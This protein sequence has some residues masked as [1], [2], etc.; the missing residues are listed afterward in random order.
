[1]RAEKV[2]VK[3]NVVVEPLFNQWYAWSYLISPVTSAL[4]VANQ[5][6]KIM[7]SFLAAPQVHVKALENPAMRGGP[8]INHPPSGAGEIRALLEQTTKGQAQVINFAASV[9]TLHEVLSQQ[10]DGHSLEPL[11]R[12]VPDQLRGYVE[13]VY[14]LNQSPSARFIE[15]LLYHSPLHDDSSQSLSLFLTERDG[16]PF[17]F[18]TPRLDSPGSLNLPL[19]FKD[20]RV[21]EFSRMKYEPGR[22]EYM[23]DLLGV[24]GDKEE[25]LATFFTDEPPQT[26]RFEGEGVR[27]RYFGHACVLVETRG[28][29]ILCDPVISYPYA[30]GPPRFTYTDLPEKLDYVLITHNHQDHCMLETLLQLRHRI[31]TILVPKNNP[32]MLADPSL[33]MA[34]KNVGFARVQEIDEMEEIAVDEG[35]ITGLPFLGEHGDLNIQSKIAYLIELKGRRVALAADSNNVEP[36]LY[37]NLSTI[38]SDVDVLFIGM[39]CEGAPLSWI[40]GP[41]L[42]RPLPRSMDQSR[43]FDGSNCEKA[44]E[45][46]RVL[47]P[48]QAYVYA[49]G[50][51]PWLTYVIAVEGE[52]ES[53]STRESQQF[54][55]LCRQRG[56]EAE[57]LYCRKEIILPPRDSTLSSKSYSF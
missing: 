31:G 43:R 9:K 24:G 16:R 5:H 20:P 2:F 17:A 32:G 3:P 27:I 13:L 40:Y 57:D 10:A 28:V 39:E 36:K 29:S 33:K 44:M 51:E 34:L 4:Y 48:S 54:I 7:Q 6:L 47:N 11:Y 52:G 45:I 8:F 55:D 21:N 41:L 50:R 22:Y 46:V 49:M 15:G 30:Q 38:T 26:S 12:Q 14:D 56:I 42:M 53:H 1:M 35:A 37:E 23:K 18:S 19:R 25:L